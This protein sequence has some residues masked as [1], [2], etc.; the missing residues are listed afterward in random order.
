MESVQMHFPM[1]KLSDNGFLTLALSTIR[2]FSHP[3][4]DVYS[5]LRFTTTPNQHIV[6]MAQIISHKAPRSSASR[7]HVYTVKLAVYKVVH[8]KI[9]PA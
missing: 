9:W 2:A 5:T 7:I 1:S 8:D 3:T 6:S 4:N